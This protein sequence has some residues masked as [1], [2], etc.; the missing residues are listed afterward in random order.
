MEKEKLF[1]KLNSK[2]YNFQLE[3]ILENKEFPEN[4][5]NLL[6]SML[7]KIEAAKK[8]YTKV[9]GIVEDKKI[10]IEEILDIIKNKCRKII[11][12]KENSEQ[13][14]EMTKRGT[15]FIVDILYSS[16]D[17]SSSSPYTVN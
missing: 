4:I 16:G 15:N 12:V 17:G 1:S 14:E 6:L 10:Y 8:D 2:D 11:V 7:Y 13:N 9:K 5:K 3:K